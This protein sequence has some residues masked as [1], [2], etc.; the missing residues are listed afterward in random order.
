MPQTPVPLAL[1]KGTE[2][3]VFFMVS[4]PYGRL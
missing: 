1:P 2:R 3:L 4:Q